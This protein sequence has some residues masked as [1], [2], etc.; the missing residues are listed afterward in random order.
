VNTQVISTRHAIEESV[1]LADEIF[2]HRSSLDPK[3]DSPEK[4]TPAQI[5]FKQDQIPTEQFKRI[6]TSW[7]TPTP[8]TIR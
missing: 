8:S 2:N 6:S 1:D 3:S 5:R 4:Q 7:S